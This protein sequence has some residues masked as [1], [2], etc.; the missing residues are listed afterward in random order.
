MS[1]S[2]SENAANAILQLAQLI[3]SPKL[4]P[5]EVEKILAWLRQGNL[6]KLQSG[7][8]AYF[9]SKLPRP[10][11]P[12]PVQRAHA[13]PGYFGGAHQAPPRAPFLI[14]PAVGIPELGN[15]SA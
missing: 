8:E 12:R 14:P 2:S 15:P 1:A 11:A 10:A 9:Q 4:Q 7:I 5:R 6:T 3:Q 13:P